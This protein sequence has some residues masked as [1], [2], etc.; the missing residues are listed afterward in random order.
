MRPYL[1][2]LNPEKAPKY[3]RA[4]LE[5][6]AIIAY[7]Q[8]VTRGDIEEIRGVTVSAPVIKTLEERSWIEAIG[9]RE[10]PGRPRCLPRRVHSSMTSVCI[11]STN[12]RCRSRH[13]GCSEFE[14]SFPMHFAAMPHHRMHSPSAGAV[15]DTPTPTNP[16]GPCP[17]RHFCLVHQPMNSSPARRRS[18]RGARAGTSLHRGKRRVMTRPWT[19]LQATRTQRRGQNR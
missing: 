8:P 12:C 11:R 2:R 16:Q 4:V 3:S 14:L 19:A 13:D 7:R 18:D 1:D 6:L 9:H 17:S 5:T 15:V 10:T